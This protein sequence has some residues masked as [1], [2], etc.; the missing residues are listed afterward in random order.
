MGNVVR[1][2]L[3]MLA[4]YQQQVKGENKNQTERRVIVGAVILIIFL[5]LGL[6][7][8]KVQSDR[9]SI[10]AETDAVNAQL[11]SPEFSEQAEKAEA[12]NREL[13]S[14]ENYN[15][16]LEYHL[17]AL[18]S[19]YRPGS[20]IFTDIERVAVINGVT[21]R[22]LN[23]LDGTVTLQCTSENA[24]RAAEFAKQL[25]NDIL[26]SV[27]FYGYTLSEGDGIYS[28]SVQGT[29]REAAEE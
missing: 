7:F 4:A 2:D 5:L 6:L 15:E 18:S 17:D 11:A 3:D 9:H 20:S 13:A 28:F 27:T 26:D 19:V 25:E 24:S 14:R 29:S 12:V 8:V 16:I 22:V 23:Y 10:A 21:C 1:K